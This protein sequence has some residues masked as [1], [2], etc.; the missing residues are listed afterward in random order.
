MTQVQHPFRSRTALQQPARQAAQKA[1]TGEANKQGNATATS[2]SAGEAART[3]EGTRAAKAAVTI[4]KASASTVQAS[5]TLHATG[6]AAAKARVHAQEQAKP[7]PGAEPQGRAGGARGPGADPEIETKAQA[8]KAAL[9]K[10]KDVPDL[11]A[12]AISDRLAKTKAFKVLSPDDK[13]ELKARVEAT[14]DEGVLARKQALQTLKRPEFA[15]LNADQQANALYG[16]VAPSLPPSAKGIREGLAE[17]PGYNKLDKAGQAAIAKALKGPNAEKFAAGLQRD[18]ESLGDPEKTAAQR[19]G[20][21]QSIAARAEVAARTDL[22]P[23]A[24]EWMGELL[25]GAAQRFGDAGP[26]AK[27]VRE[28]LRSKS[29]NKL[30]P[31][32]KERA[33]GES[34]RLFEPADT[35]RAPSA[36]QTRKALEADLAFKA[37]NPD[38]RAVLKRLT[39]GDTAVSKAAR[40]RIADLK[41]S[42]LYRHQGVKGQASMLANVQTLGGV[43][44]GVDE[45]LPSPDVKGTTAVAASKQVA[46]GDAEVARG[47]ATQHTVAIKRGKTTFNIDVVVPK[48]MGEGMIAPSLDK[49]RNALSR[50]PDDQLKRMTR[51][52]VA[53]GLDPKG[54]TMSTDGKGQVNIYPTDDPDKARA[55][56]QPGTMAEILKHEVGHIASLQPWGDDMKSPGWK[57]WQAAMKQDGLRPSSYAATN[58]AEDF[59][60]AYAAYTGTDGDAVARAGYRKLFPA[61]FAVLDKLLKVQGSRS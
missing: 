15:K 12:K 30:S 8:L 32:E 51:I 17:E 11:G 56:Q 57:K 24:K 9:A 16:A 7:M 4:A 27:G 29:F 33:V 20:I 47:P 31:A 3:V 36:D 13:A 25:A 18:V 42:P 53:E 19:A 61:R 40:A 6:D 23:D 50:L 58:P 43:P 49:I 5:R 54:G 46:Q 1:A 22:S 14:D 26:Y 37:M 38:E 60:E 52:V 44:H 45:Q 28:M 39:S 59:A 48:K 21:L 41:S 34:T 55:E 35:K 2:S 10:V